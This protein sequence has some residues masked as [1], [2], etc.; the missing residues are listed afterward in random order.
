MYFF[1]LP[2]AKC[3]YCNMIFSLDKENVLN[4]VT[5]APFGKF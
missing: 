4:S 5:F 1:F 2:Y 3:L